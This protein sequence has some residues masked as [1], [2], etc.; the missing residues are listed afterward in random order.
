MKERHSKGRKVVGEEG[1]FLVVAA[2]AST[3][4][5]NVMYSSVSGPPALKYSAPKYSFFVYYY[6]YWQ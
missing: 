4:A 3:D 5:C 1:K 2:S 6:I